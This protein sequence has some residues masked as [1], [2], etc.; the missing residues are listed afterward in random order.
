MGSRYLHNVKTFAWTGLATHHPETWQQFMPWFAKLPEW[1]NGEVETKVDHH[2]KTMESIRQYPDTFVERRKFA[3][4]DTFHPGHM[5]PAANM[6]TINL[7]Y[8]ELPHDQVLWNAVVPKDPDALPPKKIYGYKGP[9]GE[10]PILV[11]DYLPDIKF[12]S[13]I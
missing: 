13:R 12:G 4:W 6:K 10:K 3:T 11:S 7:G 2:L 8:R 5:L 9:K 1:Q